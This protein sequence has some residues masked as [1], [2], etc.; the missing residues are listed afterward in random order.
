MALKAK[1]TSQLEKRK[2]VLTRQT[3]EG[4]KA[5]PDRVRT[6]RKQLKRAYRQLAKLNRAEKIRQ[7]KAGAA[8]D[9]AATPAS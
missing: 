6:T 8:K 1:I 9:G 2:A 5:T 4:S 3:A 7:G